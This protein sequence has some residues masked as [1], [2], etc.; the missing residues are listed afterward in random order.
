MTTR[1]VILLGFVG[2]MPSV[3]PSDTVNGEFD[4]GRS[5][6]ATPSDTGG[7]AGSYAEVLLATIASD[8]SLGAV[9]TVDL[10]TGA[11]NDALATTSGDAVI[12]STGGLAVVLNRFNTDSVRVY[13]GDDWSQ[14]E[15]ESPSPIYRTPKMHSC[16][17]THSGSLSTMLHGSLA[18]TPRPDW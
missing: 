6:T 5:D 16:A 2:C 3:T 10:E 18:T 11:V 9:A 13:S 12:R 1:I 15:L 17:T 14:P 4:T 7:P 8:Y